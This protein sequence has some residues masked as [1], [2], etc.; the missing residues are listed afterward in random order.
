MDAE[1]TKTEASIKQIANR[2]RKKQRREINGLSKP[3]MENSEHTSTSPTGAA[4]FTLHSYE[5]NLVYN[6]RHY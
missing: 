2:N 3:S 4:T 6:E 1:Q 5:A